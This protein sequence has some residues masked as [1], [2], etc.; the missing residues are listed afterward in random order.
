MNMS[1]CNSRLRDGGIDLISI[2]IDHKGWIYFH[3]QPVLSKISI[4]FWH[5]LGVYNCRP[6]KFTATR[7]FPQP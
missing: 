1:H 4:N 6:D 7:K 3:S 2:E 5:K